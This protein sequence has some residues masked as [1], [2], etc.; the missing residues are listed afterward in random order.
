[1]L[2]DFGEID[3]RYRDHWFWCQIFPWVDQQ[4]QEPPSRCN[5]IFQECIDNVAQSAEDVRMTLMVD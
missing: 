1:M 5:L 2:D 4:P 3:P